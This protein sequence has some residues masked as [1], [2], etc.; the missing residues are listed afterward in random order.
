MEMMIPMT[1]ER[2]YTLMHQG[3]GEEVRHVATLRKGVNLGHIKG[4][5]LG[6]V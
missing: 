6:S 4:C 3:V 5:Y 2:K 1:E